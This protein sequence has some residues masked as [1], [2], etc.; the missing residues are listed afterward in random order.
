MSDKKHICWFLFLMFCYPAVS[1]GSGFLG[2]EIPK[3]IIL[4]GYVRDA[5]TGETLSDA[6]IYLKEKSEKA[7]TTNSYGYFSLSLLSGSYAIVIQ[8]MGYKT[9]TI[10]VD[11][12]ENRSVSVDMEEESIALNEVVVTGERGNRNI[13]ST[14]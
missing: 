3:T 2:V 6:F 10:S 7:A 1:A 4:S 13:V 11:L 14:N 5:K 8:S 12:K 9:K